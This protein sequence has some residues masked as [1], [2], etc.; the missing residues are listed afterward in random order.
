MDVWVLRFAEHAPL[1]YHGLEEVAHCKT[2]EALGMVKSIWFLDGVG[3]QRQKAIQAIMERWP[4]LL[5]RYTEQIAQQQ[6]AAL[7][8]QLVGPG[9]PSSGWQGRIFGGGGP[10]THIKS[11]LLHHFEI[12]FVWHLL[13]S[14]SRQRLGLTVLFTL[15]KQLSVL[16]MSIQRLLL[17]A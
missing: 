2:E 1:K 11:A 7:F 13:S 9:N 12:M 6:M 10:H 8:G 3:E 14:S 4:L 5:Q 17:Q 15:A 16:Y